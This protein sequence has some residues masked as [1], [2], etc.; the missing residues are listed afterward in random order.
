MSN[1]K[2]L[3]VIVHF[4]SV[5]DPLECIGSLRRLVT[6]S[7]DIF[8]INNGSDA[9]VE[10]TLRARHPD[11]LYRQAGVNVGFAAGN[12][13]G[14]RFFLEHAYR[15]SLLIN[16]D[17]V[18]EQDFLS[19]LINLLEHDPTIAMAGPAIYYY[20]DKQ[21]LWSCG[22]RINKWSGGLGG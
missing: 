13:I 10:A 3:V 11:I 15:Y 1:S 17:T 12:N 2:T 4:G 8:V 7:F 6:C 20:H 14:L 21:R 22:G 5:A 9:T 19:P 18:A 16:N